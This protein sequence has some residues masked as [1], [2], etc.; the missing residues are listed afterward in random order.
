MTARRASTR[1]LAL[2][3]LLENLAE[4]YPD[5]I[6][7]L[8]HQL[9]SIDGWP[10]R[11]DTVNVQ[12]TSELT[13]V[14]A[15]ANAR[16]RYSTVTADIEAG[17]TLITVT[18]HDLLNTCHH[19]LRK[20]TISSA[21]RTDRI[22]DCSG[23]EGAIVPLDEGGWADPTCREHATKAGLCGRCYFRE[24]RWRQSNGLPTRQDNDAA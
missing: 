18:I 9:A 1:I 4:L 20:R 13:S 16:L 10:T 15:S 23:R 7:H 3:R 24:R 8:D 19:E 11:G 6:E 14:E 21:P 12:A 2:S 17:I 22:C 5:T